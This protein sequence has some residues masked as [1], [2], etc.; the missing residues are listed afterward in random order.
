MKLIGRMEDEA[1]KELVRSCTAGN[2]AE[3]DVGRVSTQPRSNDKAK[4]H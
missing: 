3:N 1:N 4:H 2:N